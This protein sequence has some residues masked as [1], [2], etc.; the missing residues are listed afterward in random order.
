MRVVVRTVFLAVLL[1]VVPSFRS[2]E[3]T[4][5]LEVLTR[6]REEGFNNSQ[7]MM[8][9]GHL[10]D[11]I[12]PRLTGSQG[13]RE[14]HEWTRQQ[15]ENWGLEGARLDSW[16]FGRGWEIE[17]VS[18]H[19]RQPYSAPLIA[20]P[21]AW[22]PGTDGAVRSKAI[23]ASL[24]SE[25]DLVAHKGKLA[26][27]I[28]LLA[29][30]AQLRVHDKPDLQRY[31]EQDLEDLKQYRIPGDRR[32]RGD[33]DWRKRREFLMSLNTFLLEEKVLAVIWP[34]GGDGGTLQLVRAGVSQRKE[35]AGSVPYLI[36]A[37]EQYNQM[38]RLL[39]RKVEVELELDIRVRFPQEEQKGHNTIAQ[40]PGTDLRDET[41][42][43]GG[44]ID[45]WYAGTGATDNAAGVS[46]AMEAVRIL[47]AIGVQPRRTIRIGLWGGEEQGFLGSQDYVRKYLA[48]QTETADPE[49]N[50]GPERREG[51]R[52]ELK[53]EHSKFSAYYN[54]DNGTGKIRGIYL[55]GNAALQ[56]VF[57]AW[58]KPVADLGAKT[59]TMRSTGG[60]DHLPFNSVGL[61]GF[62]FIQDPIEYSSRTWHTNMDVYDRLQA[63]DLMQASVIMAW[64]AYNTAMRSEMLPRKPMA[65]P[66]E[67]P[68]GTE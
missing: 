1:V 47:K 39:E 48:A 53:P 32:R 12:G 4:V 22:T 58:L 42:M 10:C 64:F 68:A 51:G 23:V 63:E 29:D 57:E 17:H 62:Q 54:L 66:Q 38:I 65:S 31:S 61:P 28:L 37:A 24:A 27:M 52:L 16:D 67:R 35:E 44:H 18:V 25:Q 45:S 36:V 7:V 3:E 30:A 33:M 19:L 26:G 60:T 59:V 15:L 34:A 6:I 49:T 20:F 21:L 5:D 50:R 8:T 40:I 11:V 41:V 43:V 56:P 2:E 14:A 9:A 55:Q 46:V 13:Y